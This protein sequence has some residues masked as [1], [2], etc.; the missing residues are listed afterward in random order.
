MEGS[1]L[2]FVNKDSFSQSLEARIEARVFY[3]SKYKEDE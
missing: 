2:K 3:N 1:K